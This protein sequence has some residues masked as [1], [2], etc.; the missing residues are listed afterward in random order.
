MPNRWTSAIFVLPRLKDVGYPW[1]T[2]MTVCIAAASF[3][4]DDPLLVLSMDRMG[5]TGSSSSETTWKWTPV[6]TKFTALLAGTIS[7]APELIFEID[8]G[9]QKHPPRSILDGLTAI[10]E[11]IG[12]TK[13]KVCRVL[14]T[15]AARNL[16]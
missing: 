6:G 2:V 15:E 9:F 5:S 1:N 13:T 8:R 4:N 11:A 14:H 7:N 3:F 16:L 12:A 10:R